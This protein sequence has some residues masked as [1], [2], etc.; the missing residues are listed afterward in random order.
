MKTDSPSIGHNSGAL[1]PIV[2]IETDA[3]TV[4]LSERYADISAVV[5]KQAQAYQR[6][7]EL[8][9]RDLSDDEA[10]RAGD[11]V[12]KQLNPILASLETARVSEKA[13]AL[14]A[15]R[16]IDAFF[17]AMA[18]AISTAKAGALK[19]LTKHGAAK[20]ERERQRLLLE[21][22]QRA[23]EAARLAVQ[24]E[25][26][27]SPELLNAAIAVEQQSL[28]A[29]NAASSVVATEATRTRG[30][31]GSVTSM[32]T[33]WTFEVTDMSKIPAEFLLVNDRLVT[34]AIRT[35]R[36][37]GGVPQITISGIKIIA[38]RKAIVS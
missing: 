29:K 5:T 9:T 35:A 27:Q 28:D 12:A 13:H 34:S 23:D 25:I 36:K 11:W 7:S 33:R 3:L 21:A 17:S 20:L 2:S 19:A 30:D 8:M 16:A 32:T 15:S 18:D 22:K 38:E 31:L 1:P 4:A 14:A 24:A 6:F 37:V 10:A 26:T